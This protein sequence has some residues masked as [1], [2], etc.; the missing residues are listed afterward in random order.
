[1]RKLFIEGVYVGRYRRGKSLA[2]AI[3]SLIHAGYS[4]N[5]IEVRK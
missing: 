3:L 1:M 5:R 4:R 2:R